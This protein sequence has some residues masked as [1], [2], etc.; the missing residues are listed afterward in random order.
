M[1]NESVLQMVLLEEYSRLSRMI[2]GIY[3]ELQS[4]PKGYVSKKKIRGRDSFYLQWREGDKIKSK[5]ISQQDVEMLSDMV[6]RRQE[7]EKNLR[8]NKRDMK[9]LETSLGKDFIKSHIA[10]L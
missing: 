10:E 3:K 5:Y 7:L 2:D 1:A 8:A 4:L 9:R 6:R